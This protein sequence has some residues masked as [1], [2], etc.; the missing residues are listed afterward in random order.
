MAENTKTT[1]AQQQEVVSYQ[2]LGQKREQR[3]YSPHTDIYEDSEAIFVVADIPG[4][5]EKTIDISLEKNVLTIHASP[6]YEQPEKLKLIYAEY[7]AGV[8]MRSFALSDQIDQANIQAN[9]KNGVLYL[10]LPKAG[11]VKAHRI[12]VKSE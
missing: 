10:R 6:M 4:A 3:I 1:E 5:D 2:K 7:G 12:T 11:P 8:Y 9:V